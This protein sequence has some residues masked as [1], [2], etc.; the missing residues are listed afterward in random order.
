MLQV[1]DPI[2]HHISVVRP[3]GSPP[4]GSI[5]YRDEDSI[6]SAATSHR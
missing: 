1:T 6:T 3:R 4:N 5:R 2:R